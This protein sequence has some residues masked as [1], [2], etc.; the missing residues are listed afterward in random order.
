LVVADG[1]ELDAEPAPQVL[2]NR[3][4]DDAAVL[5]GLDPAALPWLAAAERFEKQG[6][7]GPAAVDEEP[8]RAADRYGESRPSGRAAA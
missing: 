4:F 7:A 6:L 8:G 3:D 1:R 5:A 2:R